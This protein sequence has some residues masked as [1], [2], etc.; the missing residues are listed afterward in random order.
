VHPRPDRPLQACNTKVKDRRPGRLGLPSR[1]RPAPLRVHGT[2]NTTGINIAL[3]PSQTS[4]ITPVY[5]GTASPDPA[6]G[7]YLPPGP[8]EVLTAFTYRPTPGRRYEPGKRSTIRSPR[9][10]L[11]LI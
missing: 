6:V 1:R 11:T 3:E 10:P 2:G 5:F 9:T 7:Y 8:Y 4:T